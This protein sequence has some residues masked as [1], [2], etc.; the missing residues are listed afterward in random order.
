MALPLQAANSDTQNC[1]NTLGEVDLTTP[2]N[3]RLYSYPNPANPNNGHPFHFPDTTTYQAFT[4]AVGTW[5]A[6]EK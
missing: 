3:G 1:A 5:I 6:N 4:T 2:A